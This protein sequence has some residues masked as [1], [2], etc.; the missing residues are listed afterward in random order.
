M[1]TAYFFSDLLYFFLYILCG[2]AIQSTVGELKTA[3][4]E[5]V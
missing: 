1:H 5:Y 3:E 2:A 4:S